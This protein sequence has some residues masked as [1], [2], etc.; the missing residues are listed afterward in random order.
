MEKSYVDKMVSENIGLVHFH[1]KQYTRLY[2]RL[3]LDDLIQE[4]VFGLIQA[5]EKYNPEKGSFATYASLW[6]RQ[7]IRNSIN[8]HDLIK[9]PV[10]VRRLLPSYRAILESHPSLTLQ[11]ISTNL[12]IPIKKLEAV[13]IA[14]QFLKMNHISNID[15]HKEHSYN[16][17]ELYQ[18]IESLPSLQKTII[19]KKFGLNQSS[20]GV[21]QI[22]K[23]I[24]ISRQQ[25]L[26]LEK[27]ALESLMSRL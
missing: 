4:G 24:G 21:N 15:I 25:T 1:A 5:I 18:E 2:K 9:I 12:G 10:W 22:S 3:P 26:L 19:Q 23:S 20:C 6:I 7:A 14:D 16:I 8:Q 17:D 27:Q 11:E 13:Q